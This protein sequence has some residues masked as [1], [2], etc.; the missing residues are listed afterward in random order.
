MA[1][2]DSFSVSTSFTY[3]FCLSFFTIQNSV[4]EDLDFKT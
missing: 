3:Q 1:M 4:T 2:N